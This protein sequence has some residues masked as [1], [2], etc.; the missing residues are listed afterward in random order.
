M[1]YAQWKAKKYTVT[2]VNEDGT[3]LET[4]ENVPYG[5]TPTYN[6]ETPTKAADTQY[7]YL[8]LIHI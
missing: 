7:T 5:T 3:V 1:L 2:W 6:G 4:D 8:S